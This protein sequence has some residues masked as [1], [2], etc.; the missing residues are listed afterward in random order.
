MRVDGQFP[1]EVIPAPSGRYEPGTIATNSKK[2]REDDHVTD[3][4]KSHGD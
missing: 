3:G 1:E 4:A 2:G